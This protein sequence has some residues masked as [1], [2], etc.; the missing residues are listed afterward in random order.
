MP[1]YIIMNLL[2]L[3]KGKHIKV[4]TEVGVEVELQIKEVEENNHSVDLEPSTA[5]N[6]WWPAT[7]E[8]KT[9]TV[10]FTNGHKKIYDSLNQ[11]EVF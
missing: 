9:Y 6:D 1:K 7:R 8:W 2:E 5:A 4:M 11:I 3:L 10:H